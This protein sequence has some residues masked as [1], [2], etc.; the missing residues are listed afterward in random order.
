MPSI[1]QKYQN[2][3]IAMSL[4]ILFLFTLMFGQATLYP[5]VLNYNYTIFPTNWFIFIL[6]CSLFTFFV[7][8]YLCIRIIRDTYVDFIF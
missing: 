5:L 7:C 8:I 2:T 4:L 1:E 3:R 6:T